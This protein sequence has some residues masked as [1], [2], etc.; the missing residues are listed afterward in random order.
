MVHQH[1]IA[2]IFPVF[3]LLG[4]IRTGVILYH[5]VLKINLQILIVQFI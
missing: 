4:K 3:L 1:I 5:T 2:D